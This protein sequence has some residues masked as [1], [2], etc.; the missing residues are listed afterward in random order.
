[1][2]LNVDKYESREVEFNKTKSSAKTGN[3]TV[4]SGDTI[5]GLMKAFNFKNEQE[6]REY[7]KISGTAGLQK[8]AIINLPSAKLETT[9]A[10][11]A[12]KYNLTPQELLALNPQI[13]DPSKLSKGTLIYVPIRPFPVVDSKKDD[14]K[15][16]VQSDTSGSRDVTERKEQSEYTQEV[17]SSSDVRDEQVQVDS[18]Q[19]SQ[20][21]EANAIA[22]GLEDAGSAWTWGAVSKSKFKNLLSEI[23]K[24]NVKD[25]IVAYNSI[26]PKESLIEMICSEV[27]SSEKARKEA[28]MGIY[29]KLASAVDSS[30]ATQDVRKAFEAELNKGFDKLVGFV[31]TEKLDSIINSLIAGEFPADIPISAAPDDTTIMVNGRDSAF[32]VATL[33]AD[34]EKNARNWNRVARRPRPCV[35]ENGNIVAEVQIFGATGSG[36]LDGKTIIVNPGHGGAMYDSMGSLN[37][38][39]G[40]SNAAIVTKKVGGKTF[41]VEH[42]SKFIGNN[43][44]A[45]EEWELNRK[46]ADELTEKLTSQGAKVVYVSG[47]AHVVP[48]TIAKY[49][50]DADMVVSLHANALKSGEG[51]MIIPTMSKKSKLVDDEDLAFAETLYEKFNSNDKFSGRTKLKQQALAVLRD[52]DGNAYSGPDI[53]IETGNLKNKDD[54]SRLTN[55][56][57]RSELVSEINSGIVEYLTTSKK[58]AYD[59]DAIK[60]SYNR[61]FVSVK[62]NP[63]HTVKSGE[64]LS[65]IA[66][67]AGVSVMSI[68]EL[69]RLK[70]SSLSVGQVLKMPATVS[71]KNIKNL[72]DVAEATGL[73]LQYINELKKSE[74][75]A[76]FGKNDFHQT[77][78]KDKNGNWTIGIGHLI[79]SS[80]RAK[81][82]NAKLSKQEVVTLLAQ[83][84]LDRTENLKLILGADTY[85]NLPA[86]LKDAVMDF[87][88]SRGETTIKGHPGF[89]DALKKGDY[90]KAISLINID[91]SIVTDASG[92]KKKKYLA[93]MAK[94]RLFE[95]HHA[96]RI[97]NGKIPA[98]VKK[99]IQNLYNRGLMHMKKEFPNKKEYANIKAGFDAQVREWFGDEI[100][101]Q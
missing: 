77:A 82:M 56:R 10:A 100:N 19:N 16:D 83:D 65:T 94:R 9:V 20:K 7:I 34:W 39:P 55:P 79:K 2:D 28:V 40:T 72:S 74:D 73:T 26:S 67:N 5:Y 57:Y 13:K 91:Y 38:D 61:K 45:L 99:T 92:Q 96:C 50:A 70:S 6:F 60:K 37:F 58:N 69:N 22:K 88:F 14:T 35:D 101:Y 4:K 36:A 75:A 42:K 24:S 71:A 11:L 18:S 97:Y 95:I 15:N 93:G 33:Q 30:V 80:E 8:G 81:Y 52:E 17:Q 51:V 98:E 84:I 86:P 3:Y 62:E 64:N 12:R 89:V 76:G 53:L 46:F 31:P 63:P 90:D 23:D 48:D 29:D 1:M 32:T 49:R 87:V 27:T 54:V 85:N 59:V 21:D 47:S 44:V 41:E 43:G 78:Y 66:E 25:V 68:I